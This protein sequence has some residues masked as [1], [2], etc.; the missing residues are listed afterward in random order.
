MQVDIHHLLTGFFGSYMNNCYP[1]WIVSAC[2][3]VNRHMVDHHQ[4][5]AL[6]SSREILVLANFGLVDPMHIE[7]AILKEIDRKLTAFVCF[8]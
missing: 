1:A 4:G 3:M 6:D 2:H 7:T 5:N 8:L